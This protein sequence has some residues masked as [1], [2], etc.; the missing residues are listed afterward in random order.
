[1]TLTR[2]GALGAALALSAPALAQPEAF[3]T[4][5]LRLVVPFA[6]GG[7]MDIF[8]RPLVD[9]LGKLL[10]Q[11]VVFDNRPGANGIV[12]TQMVATAPAD[13]YTLLFTTGSFIGN[14]VFSPTPLPY[15]PMRD[16]A[17]V[18]LV[19]GGTG[20][21][22]VGRPGLP[23]QNM[24]EL[25]ALAK[26]KAGGLSCAISGIG[27]ITH[28]GVEQFQEFTRTE[29]LQVTL[30]G[31]GPAI[32]EMLAGNVDLT[33]A[34]VPPVLPFLRD[35][36]LRA[37]GYT[38]LHR[39]YVLPDVPTMREAGF[40][41]WEL[42]GMLGLWTTG[43]TPPDRIARIQRAV[44]EVV[45]TPEVAKLYRDGEFD[46]SGMPPAEFAVYLQKEL[47]MQEGIARR[48]GLTRK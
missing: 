10:G 29:L 17:P 37:F 3:P 21:L 7:P 47:A 30:H 11:P 19:G 22:L 46:P 25:V 14:I 4:R 36:K 31:T 26:A 15:D 5:P 44:R 41:E 42:I 38:G 9:R 33:F 16:I 32:T 13:G 1:M 2:R 28:L 27:N 39:P 8:G 45:N 12:G 6:P 18:T 34:T 43:G 48:V 20:M 35:G 23:A 24:A 40:P